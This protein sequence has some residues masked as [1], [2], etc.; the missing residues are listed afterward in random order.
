MSRA[1]SPEQIVKA[2]TTVAL[3]FD[4]SHVLSEFKAGLV[5]EVFERLREQGADAVITDAEWPVL[6]HAHDAMLV[7]CGAPREAH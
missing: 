7:A 3:W 4:W 5:G 2:G 6:D 1:L